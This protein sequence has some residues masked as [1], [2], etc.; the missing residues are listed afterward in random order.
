MKFYVILWRYE[1]NSNV[2]V[3]QVFVSKAAASRLL[4]ILADHGDLCKVF[5]MNEV[6]S[7]SG[8]PGTPVTDRLL[9]PPCR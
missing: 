5:S 2:G 9:G 6:E 1:D 8:N 3:V 7:E 4:G